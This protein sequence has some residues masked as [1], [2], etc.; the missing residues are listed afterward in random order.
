MLAFNITRMPVGFVDINT[1]TGEIINAKQVE[2]S[3]AWKDV[4]TPAI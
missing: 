4:P 2:K 3:T 1:Q